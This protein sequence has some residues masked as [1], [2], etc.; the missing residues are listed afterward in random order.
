MEFYLM[1]YGSSDLQLDI[2]FIYFFKNFFII[3]M[4]WKC[5]IFVIINL[6]MIIILLLDFINYRRKYK[7]S[8]KP[9]SIIERWVFVGLLG[10]YLYIKY[11]KWYDYIFNFNRRMRRRRRRRQSDKKNNEN[12]CVN[13]QIKETKKRRS[14]TRKEYYDIYIL[15]VFLGATVAAL[16][17]FFIN[18]S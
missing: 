2:F 13:E 3:I 11:Y 16:I 4:V 1:S 14:L 10:W 9:L 15:G 18:G 17:T 6:F 5:E 7:E 8:D 12:K